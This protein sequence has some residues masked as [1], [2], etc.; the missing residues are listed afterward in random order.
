MNVGDDEF[1]H[2]LY[3]TFMGR[4]EDADG[5]AFWKSHLGT[6]MTREDLVKG[7]AQSQEFTNICNEYGIDK[8]LA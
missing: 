1:I 7:F 4:D 2:R 8:G 5:F 3:R 6:D